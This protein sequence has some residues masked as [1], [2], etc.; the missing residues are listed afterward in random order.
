M[1]DDITLGSQVTMKVVKTPTNIAAA[2]TLVRLLC[3][4]P[5]VK[6]RNDYLRKVRQAKYAPKRRGGRLYGGRMVKLKPVEA[7]A[8][9]QGQFRCSADILGDLRSVS[10]FI[11]VVKA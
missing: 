7:K 5:Q 10:K 11:E 1:L 3:R 8:G 6:A 4:D 9:V 2:K